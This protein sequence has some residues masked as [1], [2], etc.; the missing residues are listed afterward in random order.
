MSHVNKIERKDQ[1]INLI[2][3]Y[4]DSKKLSYDV[5]SKELNISRERVRQI[6]NSE[7]LIGY[8]NEVKGRITYKNK[9]KVINHKE[10]RNNQKSFN[11]FDEKNF[12]KELDY[13]FNYFKNNKSTIRDFV[14]KHYDISGFTQKD[15]NKISSKIRFHLE[16]NNIYFIAERI[17]KKILEEIL[18]QYYFNQKV[19][20]KTIQNLL[21]KLKNDGII[22]YRIA[23]LSNLKVKMKR[24][25]YDDETIN[26]D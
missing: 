26:M 7:N 23:N 1:I 19:G 2:D 11:L 21:T 8:F 25:G 24:W 4:K 12:E 3:K 10:L 13:I 6:L 14:N 5:L 16:K 9:M 22:H 18:N 20:A 17:N 15:L